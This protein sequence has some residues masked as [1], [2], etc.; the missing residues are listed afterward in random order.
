MITRDEHGRATIRATRVARPLRIDGRLDEAVYTDV[1]PISDFIQQEPKEGA[2]ASE[3]TDV[4]LSYD[5]DYVYVSVRCWETSPERTVRREMRRDNTV[6]FRAGHD[7]IGFMFDTYH[8]RRSG[9]IFNVNAVGGRTDGQFP[10]ERQY[11]GD[12]NPIWDVRTGR[13]EHGWTV[14]A[15]IPF[16]SL[17]YQP[18]R[19]QEWGFNLRRTSGWR[20]ELSYITR[21]PAG[22]S[23]GGTQMAAV[24]ATVVGLEAPPLA[25]NL[26]L[27]PYAASTASTIATGRAL[28][29]DL[30]L[31]VGGDAKYS[32][33]QNLTAD[34]TVNTDFA[35]VEADEQQVNLT[36]FSLFFPEKR[37]FFLE[38]DT[39]FAFGGASRS[40]TA[41]NT[42]VLFYS[43]QIGLN[44][45]RAVPIAAGGRVTGRVGKVSLGALNIQAEDEQ[46]TNARATNFTVLRVKRDVL[47][48]SSIGALLTHR[49][50]SASRAGSNQ[51][52]GVDGTFAFFSNLNINTYVAQTATEG[53]DTAPWSYRGQFDYRGDR[54]GLELERLMVGEGFNPE[55]GFLR[56]Q[57]FDRHYGSARFSP[58]FHARSPI[59]KLSWEGHLDYITGR[60]TRRLETRELFGQV[61]VEL[62]S[63]DQIAMA[64]TRSYE[65]LTQPF[66]IA[67]S[68]TIPVGGYDFADIRAAYTMGLQRSVSGQISAQHGSFYEGRRTTIGASGA[69]LNLSPQLSVEPN[70]SINWVDLPHG[71]FTSHVIGSRVS[72]S[73]T[74]FMFVAALVQYQ[75]DRRAVST[76]VRFRWEY[77]PG[78]EL[79]VVLN[80]ERDTSVPRLPM[81]Q[82]R[83]LIVK[84][85]RLFRF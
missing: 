38:N 1:T 80:E 2:P 56:R 36:R 58:R 10:N 42:P 78:S 44:R 29:H 30:G 72:Y 41:G 6:I 55:V 23:T 45:G 24:A 70:V 27:K 73:M 20:N 13:F 22:R 65:Y 15:A 54:Y 12:W 9:Y 19:G 52:Y 67:P 49:S 85:N 7:S 59:R 4:W 81:L 18:Q 74:P 5:G 75:S 77:L 25:R 31:Q 11:N 63:S 34:V 82:N 68:V 47:R 35:Q 37:E 61:G 76:N 69:R 83:S 16:K 53:V 84:V 40:G 60:R 62:R 17:R 21:V 79:F 43:R 50:V 66:P 64:Y 8:D 26:E 14:E 32:V 51:A 39:L 28:D 3:K 57:A 33:T 48:R 46:T 71:A